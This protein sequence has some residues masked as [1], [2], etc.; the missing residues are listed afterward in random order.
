MKFE[1]GNVVRH[2][3]GGPTMVISS[4]EDNGLCICSWHSRTNDEFKQKDFYPEE[5]ELIEKE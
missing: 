2:K 4:I 3:A 5:L 1:K